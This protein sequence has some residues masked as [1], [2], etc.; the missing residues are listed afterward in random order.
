MHPGAARPGLFALRAGESMSDDNDKKQADL[1][2]RLEALEAKNAELLSEVKAERQKRRDAEAA[3]AEADEEARKKAEEAAAASGDVDALRKQLEAKHA[4]DIEK[5]TKER[6]DATGQLQRLV[7][8]GGI[9]AALDAAGMAPAYKR[10]LR[11]DFE[12]EHQIDIRDGQAFVGGEALA[13]VVKK[14][15]ETEAVSGLKAAG[16]GSGSGAPGGGKTA[17]KTLAEMGDAER[18][19]LARE[20]KLKAAVGQ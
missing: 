1:E 9:D 20:G 3:K 5:L 8:E 18:L 10:M 6:D 15:T 11:R 13:D 19:A 12:A 16:H 17:G 4:K 14:W 2:K 7:V